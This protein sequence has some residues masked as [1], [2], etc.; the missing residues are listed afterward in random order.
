MKEPLIAFIAV[1]CN[2]GAQLAAKQA[3]TVA[4]AAKGLQDWLSPWLLVA[5][6]LYGLAFVLMMRVYAVNP[7]SVAS[8]IMAGAVF[9]LIAITSALLLGEGM[10]W[11]KICG[12]SLIFFGIVVLSRS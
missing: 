9:L 8:P 7:L 4:Q 3:G 2:V 10:G 11:Q 12:I 5:L 6:A 1:C